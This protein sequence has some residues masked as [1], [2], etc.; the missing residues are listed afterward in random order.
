MQK[1][2]ISDGAIDEVKAILSA[3]TAPL[4][5]LMIIDRCTIV[6]DRIEVAKILHNLV[7]IGFA[8]RLGQLYSAASSVGTTSCLGQLHPNSII[9]KL[10]FALFSRTDFI[11]SA[12]AMRMT[13]IP[14]SEK[15]VVLAELANL[16]TC[17]F[18]VRAGA[19]RSL[20]FKW[21]GTYSYPFA[22][23]EKV[24]LFDTDTF[25]APAALENVDDEPVSNSEFAAVADEFQSLMTR[26]RALAED[27]NSFADRMSSIAAKV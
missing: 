6:Q 12:E 24:A 16:V 8:I 14:L 5:S 26:A 13:G 3:S 17:K 10:A 19:H 2:E 4:S 9:G 23:K 21:S 20:R 27:F 18:A 25:H 15:K 22:N 7:E 11:S 1:E